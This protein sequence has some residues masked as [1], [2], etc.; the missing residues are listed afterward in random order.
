[1]VYNVGKGGS[2]MSYST[3]FELDSA[4]ITSEAEVETRLLA[5]LFSDLG[6]PSTS[7]VPKKHIKALRIHD[8][9]S[10]TMKEVD[11][12]LKDSGGNARIVV[13]A[14][15]PSVN[16]LYAWGQAASYALSYNRDKTLEYEKIKWLL[17]SNGYFTALFRH[18][19][20]TPIVTLQLSDFASGT[21]PYVTLRTYIKYGAVQEA[22]KAVLPFESLPPRKLNQLF[23]D[24]HTLVWKKEKLAPADAFFEFCKFIFIKIR[25]DKKR[26]ELPATTEPYMIPLTEEWLKVQSTT[27][28]HPVRDILFKNLHDELED[29]IQTQGKKRIF[30]KDE[31]LKLSAS[32]CA[33]L[34]RSF[35]SVNLSS[36][37]EDLNGRMFEVFL[38]ASI[39]GK[40]LGQFF[41]PRSVVDF[42]TRIAL[43]DVDIKKP[44]RVLDACCGTAGFL[45]EVMAYLT[46]RLRND[47]RLTD[48]ERESIRRIICNECL[49]GIEANERVTRI[50]RINMYLH[51]DGGSHI[52]HGDGLDIDPPIS[53]D[54]TPEQRKEVEE[55]KESIV[56][57]TFDLILTNPPFSMNYSSSN[58]EEKRILNQHLLTRGES[59]AKSS[60]L[61]LNRYLELL[62][63]GGEMLIILDDTVINGKSYE[64]VRTWILD[65]FVVLGVH[66]LPFNAFFK[67]KANIKTSILHLRKKTNSTEQQC[68]IFM[69]ISNNI[70]HDNSL[71]DTPFRNNLTETLIAYLEWQRTGEL[72]PTIRM[73]AEAT[74]NLE[75][76]Q[77]YW[78]VAPERLSAERFDAFFYCPDLDETFSAVQRAAIKGEID[79]IRGETLARRAKLSTTDKALLRQ[80][81]EL[82]KYIEIG[83][84][85][86]YGLITKYLEG[87]FEDL[88]TRGEYQIHTGDVLL[89]LNNSSRG[90]VVLVP[91]EFDGAICTS[92]FLVIVPKDKEEGLLLWYALRS[93]ICRKQIYYLAQ[94]ASQPELKIDAWNSYFVIPLPRGDSRQS[95]LKRIKEYYGYLAKLTDIDKYRFSL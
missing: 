3:L 13:E 45:I 58:I 34:I 7:I 91:P 2:G 11:F 72:S 62:A 31:T 21:P 56:N 25:E 84:V 94:T 4:D 41:T 10:T 86:Q 44:P 55:F 1:M 79:L 37:D 83:D 5:K 53:P 6:Y 16:I 33:D 49:Y 65:N 26:E 70:G 80:S 36:I 66:S 81:E 23:A 57:G 89:A 28:N 12:L 22:P 51:G 47:T 54:M 20:I 93:E 67:A 78:L 30:E 39:R 46:G 27:S 85:T 61:F 15:D 50:A 63:D 17:I 29:A 14:K 77:Q 8:G 32:T 59:S 19:N 43:R 18:D 64:K 87:L 74:E 76:P 40:D 42:M 90:T 73:N 38:S 75:C 95:A 9:R 60:I 69:S 48:V 92:G 35:Q 52:F 88:P 24:S 71:H 82:Y 68:S